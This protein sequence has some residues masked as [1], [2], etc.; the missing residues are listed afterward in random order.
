MPM[1]PVKSEAM[2]LSQK[3]ETLV[4]FKDLEISFMS[5]GK[6]EYEADKQIRSAAVS[7]PLYSRKPGF[8]Y[9]VFLLL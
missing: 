2:V 5:D 9:L 1:L 7:Q 6:R 4:G 3:R 8:T